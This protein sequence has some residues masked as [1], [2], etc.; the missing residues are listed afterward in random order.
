MCCHTIY[1]DYRLSPNLIL[2]DD[3]HSAVHRIGWEPGQSAPVA[4]VASVE[5]EMLVLPSLAP[6]AYSARICDAIRTSLFGKHIRLLQSDVMS[7]LLLDVNT[8]L[9]SSKCKCVARRGCITQSAP[10]GIVV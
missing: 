6:F 1:R 3:A 4:A 2:F 8:P 9:P 10:D 5:R 7:V